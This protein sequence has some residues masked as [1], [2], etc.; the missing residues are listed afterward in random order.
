MSAASRTLRTPAELAAA[1]LLSEAEAASLA[2][3]AARYAIAVTPAMAALIAEGGPDDPIARQLIPDARELHHL[4]HERAD[5][6][7]DEVHAKLPGLVHRYPDRVLLKLTHACPVYCRFCFRREVVGPGGDG[8]L[9]GD[10]M[11]PALAYIGD[12]PAIREAILTG[13]D[14]LVLSPRR[15]AEVTARLAQIPHL[16]VLRWHTRVPVVDPDRVDGDL[17]AALQSTAKAVYVGIHCNH[18]RELTAAARTA[19]GRLRE[20]RLNLVSQT[21]LL[22]G[23]NDD[24]T[25]LEALFRAFVGLGIRPY[26]LHH[27]DLA[28]GT[29]HFR[30]SIAAGQALMRELRG[31]VTGLALPTYVLDVPGGYGKVP[32]GPG[33]VDLAHSSVSDPAGGRHTHPEAVAPGAA[34]DRT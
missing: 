33:Y 29:A 15:I 4:P 13:G 8:I 18:P 7:G 32:A 14:P 16:D 21:V 23:V 6:I 30:T 26:Y 2:P 1:G 3:V 34:S 24:A 17:V 31:R 10:A 27:A 28:P 9:G 11:A 20:A 19:I 12:R 25:T 22:A 5:P